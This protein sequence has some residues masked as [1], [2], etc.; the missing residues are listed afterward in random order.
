[1]IE[2]TELFLLKLLKKRIH[3]GCNL[4]VSFFLQPQHCLT[5]CVANSNAYKYLSIK[6]KI[7]EVLLLLSS[8]SPGE[9]LC[10]VILRGI[11]IWKAL[12]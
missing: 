8:S 10:G 3:E 5:Q 9:N 11:K 4:N 12:P 7:N 1:M 2:G 6:K